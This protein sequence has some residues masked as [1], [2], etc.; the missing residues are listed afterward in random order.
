[1]DQA[2]GLLFF[3]ET[4]HSTSRLSIILLSGYTFENITKMAYGPS[5]LRYVD[6]L[7]AGPFVR[8]KIR[9]E[10]LAGSEN[11]TY[12]FFSNRI[13]PTEFDRVSD[14]EV[15]IQPDGTLVVSGIQPATLEGLGECLL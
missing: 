10:K 8:E 9:P 2:E 14:F 12:H 4:I 1:M 5:I 15:V 11:K 6:V 7:I 3:L 13:T